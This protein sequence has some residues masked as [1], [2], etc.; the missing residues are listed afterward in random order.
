[1]NNLKKW[2]K[3][4]AIGVIAFVLFTVIGYIVKWEAQNYLTLT[5]I[6]VAAFSFWLINFW[7]Q[8]FE[9][10]GKAEETKRNPYRKMFFS[11]VNTLSILFLVIGVFGAF[12]IIADNGNIYNAIALIIA[13]L[14]CGIFIRYFIWAVYFYNINY[15]LTDKDWE[16]ILAA[17]DKKAKGLHVPDLALNAPTSNPFKDQTFGLPKGT[18]RGMIAFTLLFA[19]IAL[20]VVSM[21]M[22]TNIDESSFFWDHFEFVK[23]AFLMMI[24]FYFGDSSLKYLSERWNKPGSR[25][26]K[27]PKIPDVGSGNQNGN[28]PNGG[29]GNGGSSDQTPAEAEENVPQNQ[30]THNPKGILGAVNLSDLKKTI[31]GVFETTEDEVNENYAHVRDKQFNKFITDEYFEIALERI[32]TETG[33]NIQLATLKAITEVESNGTGF[34]NSGKAKI[35]FEG[36][37][38]WKW[39]EKFNLNP[40][41]FVKGNE[42]IIYKKWT[43][44][45]YIG[46]EGEY[47]RLNRAMEIH[48]QAAIYSASWGKFQVLGENL[49]HIIKGR[50][51][52]NSN[53]KEE[54]I[55]EKYYYEDFEDF[56]VKQHESEF[57]HLLDFIEFIKNKKAH[58]TV[59][60]EY[61]DG[62]KPEKFDWDSFAYGYNGPRYKENKYVE[63]LKSA[64]EYYV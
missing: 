53:E 4:W 36:H 16:K 30:E 5:Y 64:Y 29:N 31:S 39:L 32:K 7:Y 12:M 34:L 23:T 38:F 48:K 40:E 54:E 2:I 60:I 20:T 24:A 52:S 51:Q 28:P 55:K 17:R 49:E 46:K 59:L 8:K 14:W 57:Y 15:G 56:A 47:S 13:L 41:D 50:L 9:K 22:D 26:K 3:Y 21:G 35:L 11:A 42:D 43:K 44:D 10:E 6:I 33:F 27:D 45:Y 61:I 62:N 37:K 18:V 63:K 19:A 1:M 25:R 58:G